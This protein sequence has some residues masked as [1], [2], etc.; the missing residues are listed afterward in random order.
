MRCVHRDG[1]M[2]MPRAGLAFP[3]LADAEED[4]NEHGTQKDS[5]H[6]GHP[7]SLQSATDDSMSLHHSGI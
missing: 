2:L 6:A 5:A 1:G 7:M 3:R 4:M